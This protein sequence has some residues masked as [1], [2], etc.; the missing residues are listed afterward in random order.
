M[1]TVKE[2]RERAER[3][4]RMKSYMDDKRTRELLETMAMECERRAE[5]LGEK[6]GSIGQDTRPK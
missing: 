1:T 4:S 2:R 5:H 3:Y 6:N